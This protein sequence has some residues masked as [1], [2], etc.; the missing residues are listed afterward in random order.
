MSSF[1]SNVTSPRNPFLIYSLFTLFI[2]P[3]LHSHFFRFQG[4]LIDHPLCTM[5][6]TVYRFCARSPEFKD[7]EDTV[8]AV[9]T[10]V[11][12]E[13]DW[14]T[15]KHRQHVIKKGGSHQP[16][17]SKE[18]P[19]KL[20]LE[21]HLERCAWS[22]W[23]WGMEAKG[24]DM[25]RPPER[26]AFCCHT[27]DHPASLSA[28]WERHDSLIC[29]HPRV[30]TL[31]SELIMSWLNR[32]DQ[33]WPTLR[34]KQSFLS[35]RHRQHQLPCWPRRFKENPCWRVGQLELVPPGASAIN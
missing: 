28:L 8:T 6:Y 21:L 24:Q 22:G 27:A 16:Q 30:P 23:G 7:Q 19:E 26:L 3:V 13:G 15:W 1:C 11:L 10:P 9:K 17:G 32:R 4:L 20:N 34:I 2:K 25:C 18:N 5:C 12:G 29:S 14:W 31:F 35:S 33:Q